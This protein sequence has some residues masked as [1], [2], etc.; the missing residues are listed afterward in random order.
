MKNI[1]KSLVGFLIIILVIIL[2]VIGAY[3]AQENRTVK[4]PPFVNVET[5]IADVYIM[6]GESMMPSYKPEQRL[7]IVDDIASITYSDVVIFRHDKALLTK[8]VVALPGDT[9]SIGSGTL[10]VNNKPFDRFTS[11]VISNFDGS[12]SE[13]PKITLGQD[14]YFVLGD[15]T[16]KSFDS[17]NFGPIL[18]SAI[19]G[20]VK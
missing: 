12:R 10:Y 1:Q 15:N 18:K 6:S 16:K 8:R 5:N 17:R 20:K 9:V 7:E 14:E 11:E 4:V 13:Y 2:I 3:Y 19:V